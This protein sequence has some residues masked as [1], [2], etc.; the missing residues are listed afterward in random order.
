MSAICARYLARVSDK[1]VD[2]QG[3]D[4]DE[5]EDEQP[6]AESRKNR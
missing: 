3:D 4:E 5:D 1:I 2:V 6:Q